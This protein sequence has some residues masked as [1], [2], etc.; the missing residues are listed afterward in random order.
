MSSLF[1]IQRF[2]DTS[3]LLAL[4]QSDLINRNALAHSGV[5]VAPSGLEGLF[6]RVEKL[7]GEFIGVPGLAH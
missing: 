6:K 1:Q 3:G 4:S 5:L 7:E 2:G